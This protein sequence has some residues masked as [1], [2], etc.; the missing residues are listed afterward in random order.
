MAVKSMFFHGCQVHVFFLWR[1]GRGFSW[2]RFPFG[3]SELMASNDNKLILIDGSSFL[4]R[5]YYKRPCH[6]RNLYHYAYAPSA[7]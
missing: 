7:A 6:G 3:V 1:W 4:Y 5:A 2:S